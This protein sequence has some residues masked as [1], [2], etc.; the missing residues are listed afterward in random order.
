MRVSCYGIPCNWV[1]TPPEVSS[2]LQLGESNNSSLTAG[3][4]ALFRIKICGV[5]SIRD[6][7]LCADG[8]ADAIGLN[9]YPHSPRHVSIET[10]QRIV[11]ALP[12]RVSKVGVFV[13]ASPEEVIH[14]YDTV[15]LDIIQLHGDE[16]PEMIEQLDNRP[17]L[18]AF[19]CKTSDA[20]QVV[21]YL[22]VCRERN[23]CI[24]GVL[25]DA[26]APG[27]YGGTGMALDWESVSAVRGCLGGVSLVLA[28]GLN[29]EN[30]SQAIQTAQPTAVDTASGVESSPGTKDPDRTRAFIQNASAAFARL[31]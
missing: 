28:G 3:R 25:L 8:G 14:A 15:G 23:A 22:R 29:P 12:P 27:K 13:N 6:A 11:A 21:A 30:V 2:A 17:V 7:L 4:I 31:G 1:E 5:T 24:L 19:R 26:Y 9:F 10:A 16:P 20:G 18:K